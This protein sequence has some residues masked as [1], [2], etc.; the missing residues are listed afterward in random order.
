MGFSGIKE[1]ET[2]PIHFS[3]DTCS[4]EDDKYSISCFVVGDRGREWSKWSAAERSRIVSEQFSGV[5]SAVGVEAPEPVNI[6]IQEW[7]KE[8]WIWGAPSPVMMPGTMTSDSGKSLREAYGRLH[9]AGT[10]TSLVWKR[11]MEGAV[12]S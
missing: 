11:Y 4:E 12:R 2:R 7:I 8:P 3:S 5:F 1:C 9:F 6:I 10:E